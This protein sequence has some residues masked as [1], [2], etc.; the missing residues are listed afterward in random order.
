L[1]EIENRFGII[2][3]FSECFTDYRNADSIE[4]TVYDLLAQRIYGLALGHEDLND[5]DDLRVDPLFATA[6]GKKDP[7]G[8]SR[9]REQ[10]KGKALAGKSTLNRLELTAAGANSKSRYKKIVAD[11][12]K[13]NE[14]FVDLFLEIEQK[15]PEQIILDIDATDDPLH[16]NQEGRFFHGYY[17]AYCY[18]PL[19]I[20]CGDHPLCA[21]LRQANGDAAA[22]T[23][24]ELERIVGRIRQ[25]WKK[26]QIVIRGDSGFCREDIMVWCEEN[27]VDYILGLPK[28]SRLKEILKQ[29]LEEAKKLCKSTGKASRVFKDFTYKTLTSWSRV[30]RV[31][32]KAEHLEK[33]SNPRFI[34][35]SLTVEQFDAK[36]L[37]EQ[38]Y[39]AR[40]EMENRIKEQQLMMFA[41]RTSTSMMRSNQLRL[42]F[43]TI[44]YVL[45]S[46]LRKV[47]LKGTDMQRAQCST[48]REKLLKIGA[49]VK[50]SVRRVAIKMTSSYPYKE[51]FAT[52][53]RNIQAIAPLRC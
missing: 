8:Q 25:Q 49:Q 27:D 48:I 33:G 5:H 51:L 31:V 13:L 3:R 21:K 28:N 26:V 29:E 4:H 10:D 22:G 17:K 16:G 18:M 42:W 12:D 34:V 36:T 45:M 6:V 19:Y 7:T 1:S 9:C 41:D 47:G 50:V 23:V 37:Y 32:G 20:F 24:Q 35:T 46:T 43:S 2:K 38:G 14:V 30:R 53:L 40:G 15:E 44:A 39:C 52:V 11:F